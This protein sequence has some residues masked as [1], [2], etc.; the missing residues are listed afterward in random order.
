MEQKV[1]KKY[2][3]VK[4]EFTPEGNLVPLCVVWDDGRKFEIDRVKQCDRAASRKAGGV[5]LRYVCLIR[6]REAVLYYEEN[7]KWFV[8]AKMQ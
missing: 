7:Y 6:G 4:A 2:V 8:E 1:E 3:R 5:G